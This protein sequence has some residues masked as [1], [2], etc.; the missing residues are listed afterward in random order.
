MVNNSLIGYFTIGIYLI[1]TCIS[2]FFNLSLIDPINH[3]V[4]DL[5]NSILNP[6]GAVIYNIG[7]I[8][9][10]CSLMIF[11]I[12]LKNL[13][14]IMK[15]GK[16]FFVLI[17]IFGIFLSFSDIMIGVFSEDIFTAHLFW[18]LTFF[19]ILLPILLF[20]GI[21]LTKYVNFPRLI[22]YYG[23]VLTSINILFLFFYIPVFEW[24]TIFSSL[25]F[26]G[27]ISYQY[28]KKGE[29]WVKATP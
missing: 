6:D 10:G 4:S 11:F 16:K 26:V 24:I 25:S 12:G 1:F 13:L 23:I 29:L 14:N 9:T 3:W 27:L 19:I 15:K 18:S 21:V 5:G 17:I 8:I 22:G 2:A 7:C 20:G 28:P